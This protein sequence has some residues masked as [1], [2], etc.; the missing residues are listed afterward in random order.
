MASLPS[1]DPLSLFREAALHDR[2][3]FE[4]YF[5]D[6]RPGYVVDSTTVLNALR[7]W[8]LTTTPNKCSATTRVRIPNGI[9]YLGNSVLPNVSSGLMAA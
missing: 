1:V 9:R 2:Q 3:K 7:S 6:C 4:H 8:G 5:P